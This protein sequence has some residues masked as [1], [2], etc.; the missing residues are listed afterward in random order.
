MSNIV[1]AVAMVLYVGSC[2]RFRCDWTPD[3]LYAVRY[4]LIGQ[5]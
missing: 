1:D 4:I 5:K 3:M 2:G